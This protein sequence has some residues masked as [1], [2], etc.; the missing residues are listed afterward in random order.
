MDYDIEEDSEDVDVFE[1]QMQGGMKVGLVGVAPASGTVYLG[2]DLHPL[3]AFPALMKAAKEQVP[4]ISTSS[5]NALYPAL[6]LRGEC[7]HDADRLRVIDNLE[8]LARESAYGK[9]H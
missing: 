5:V 7:L 3:G 2:G 9:Q 6:W 8:K 1:L 4:Y